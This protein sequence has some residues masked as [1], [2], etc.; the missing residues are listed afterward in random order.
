MTILIGIS[1]AALI[2]ALITATQANRNMKDIDN[3]QGRVDGLENKRADS[4]KKH[5]SDCYCSSCMPVN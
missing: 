1:I 2:I 4:L 3:L 5:P